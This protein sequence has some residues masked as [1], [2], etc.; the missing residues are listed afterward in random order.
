MCCVAATIESEVV[1]GEEG[2]L[3]LL[4]DPGQYRNLEETV[5]DETQ[6][7][8]PDLGS[9]PITRDAPGAN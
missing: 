1:E 3:I 6:V 5:K 9:V 4:M 8:D 2:T 7:A